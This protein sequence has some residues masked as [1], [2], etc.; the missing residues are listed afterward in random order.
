MT[1]PRLSCAVPKDELHGYRAVQ[2]NLVLMRKAGELPYGWIV[3]ATRRG[4]HVPTYK[5][6]ADFIRRM[7]GLYRADVWLRAD[8]YVEVWCES[9]SIAGVIENTCEELAVSLYPA[10]GFSSLTL[11]YEAAQQIAADVEDTD[12]TIE[13]IYVGDYDP[14]GV[15]IDRDIERKLRG[16][17]DD[18]GVT[19]TLTFHRLAITAAQI[20]EFDLPTKLRKAKDTRA[21]Y[22]ER[23]VEAEA[24]DPNLLR[25]LLRELVESFMPEGAL[26]VAKVAEESERRGLRVLAGILD[27]HDDD[28]DGDGDNDD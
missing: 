22:I 25:R 14:A 24:M 4:Y 26:A 2:E 27:D 1:D 11:A 7:A 16:H 21:L 13:I 20:I 6:Q 23:T 5:N 10:G 17:L 15:L 8:V 3:N 19:N 12:K 9:R 18:A 28:G